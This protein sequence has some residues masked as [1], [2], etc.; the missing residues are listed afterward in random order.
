MSGH[1]FFADRYFGYDDAIY[2]SLRL[3]EIISSSGKK[4]SDI[5]A[6]VPRTYTTPE[7]RLDC[8]DA[9]KFKV[10]EIA[11]AH[12]RETF[13]IIDID[14]VRVLYD[15]G[16]GLIRSSNTQPVLVMRFEAASPQRLEVIRGHIEAVLKDILANFLHPA[17]G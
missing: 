3:L 5:L 12:F 17:A 4:I 1:I 15:D 2:A 14:G 11:K 7:I 8:P 6:D 13:R 16:W 10:V 9:I